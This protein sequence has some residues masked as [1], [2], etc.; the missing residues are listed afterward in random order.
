M[1]CFASNVCTLPPPETPHPAPYTL[2][3]YTLHPTSYTMTHQPEKCPG[4]RGSGGYIYIYIYIYICIIKIKIGGVQTSAP[5][6]KRLPLDRKGGEFRIA[7]SVTPAQGGACQVVQRSRGGLVFKA[8]GLCL[9]LNSRL[10]SNKEE[11]VTPA[12]GGGCQR[13]AF[14]GV[15]GFQGGAFQGVGWMGVGFQGVEFQGVGWNPGCLI[16]GCRVDFRV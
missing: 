14:Q 4:C 3:P 13:A 16:S 6:L 12:L 10:E 1:L 11:K 5:R 2:E 8:H 15:G 7:S 9:S